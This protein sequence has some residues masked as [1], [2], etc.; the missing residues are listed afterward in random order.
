MT[1]EEKKQFILKQFPKK[2]SCAYI[3]GVG[4]GFDCTYDAVVK[5]L[6]AQLKAKDK[7]TEMLRTI[8]MQSNRESVLIGNK[9]GEGKARSIVAMLFW[10]YVRSRTRFPEHKEK[11]HLLRI[12]NTAHA[13]LKDNK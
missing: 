6:E 10:K 9:I 7:E 2:T 3:A 5:D 8:L 13:M 4:A 12:F 1:R 11:I